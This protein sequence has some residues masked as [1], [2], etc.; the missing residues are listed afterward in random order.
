MQGRCRGDT[1][2]TRLPTSMR[3]GRP[4]ARAKRATWSVRLPYWASA[5]SHVHASAAKGAAAAS[6]Q[7]RLRSAHDVGTSSPS[8]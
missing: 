4:E 7:V 2:A 5:S 6:R 1:G 3:S 8:V